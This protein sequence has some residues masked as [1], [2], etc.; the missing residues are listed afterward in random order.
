MSF[1]F[2]IPSEHRDF[3]DWHRGREHY[4]VWALDLDLPEINMIVEPCQLSLKDL[5]L[6]AYHRQPHIT[7]ALC[8]FPGCE[9]IACDS[10]AQATWLEQIE[11]LTQA[12]ISPFLLEIGAAH[13]F[14]AAPYLSVRDEAGAL[15]LLRRCLGAETGQLAGEEYVP[16]VTLGLYRSAWP[17]GMLWERLAALEVEPRELL[18]SRV[19]LMFYQSRVIGGQLASA[20]YF[21]LVE[22]RWT[23]EASCSNS[24]LWSWTTACAGGK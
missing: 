8:G 13:S 9:T 2:T 24:E 12:N 23:N 10:Y 3:V 21:D 15:S 17:A 5:L 14:A 22:G 19:H 1:Q 16:H 11:S 4:A 20:G 18:V 7:V 6:P